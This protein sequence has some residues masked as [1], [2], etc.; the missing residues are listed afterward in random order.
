MIIGITGTIGAGKSSVSNFFKDKGYL[1][2]DTDKMVHAYYEKDAPIYNYLVEQYGQEILAEDKSLN[3]K[4]LA[5]LVFN[6]KSHL[7]KL[8]SVVFPEVIKEII[9]ISKKY[10]NKVVFV[11]VPLLFE[12]QMDELFDKIIVVD[13]FRH[14]RH[15][16]LMAK[17]LELQDIKKREQ[18]QLKSLEKKR[19]GDIIINNNKDIAHLKK[20]LSKI[21]NGGML[22]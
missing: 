10:S 9:E 16:R 8:E 15:K 11:E 12:A 6:N 14:L 5:N 2:F 19:R 4:A 18:R 13:A 3:R 17:G 20:L 22:L 21:E 1:V 7:A